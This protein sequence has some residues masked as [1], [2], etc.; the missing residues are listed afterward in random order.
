MPRRRMIGTV[1][2]DKMDKTVVVAVERIFQHP[3]YKKYIRRTK[4]YKAHDE[5]N[6]CKVG[7]VVEIE[8]T[9]PLS[10]EKRWRVIRI[11]KRSELGEELP[12]VEGEGEES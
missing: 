6:E 10:R 9:R 8:E 4:K 5:K 11:V 7:D 3:K 1:T 2:S 12:K